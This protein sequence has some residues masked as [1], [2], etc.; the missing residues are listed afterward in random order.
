MKPS[1]FFVTK[2]AQTVVLLLGFLAAPIVLADIPEDPAQATTANQDTDVFEIREIIW[3]GN[4]RTRPRIMQQELLIQ[5]GDRVTAERIEQGRQDVMDLGLFKSVSIDQVPLPN[6]T[7]L[8]VTVDE[9]WYLLPLPRV[10]V[11]S[12]GDVSYGGQFRWNNLTGRNETVKLKLLVRERSDGG[13]EPR[14]AMTY[15]YPLVN[16]SPYGVHFG[17]AH[18]R[19][20]FDD[21]EDLELQSERRAIDF[22]ITRSSFDLGPASKGLKLGVGALWED[23][24][25]SGVGAPVSPGQST[26]LILTGDYN[27]RVIGQYSDTGYSVNTRVEHG[28]KGLNSDFE[29]NRFTFKYQHAFAV[30]EGSDQTFAIGFELGS[31]HGGPG[32]EFTEFSLGGGSTLRGFSRNQFQGDAFYLIRA[33]YLRPIFGQ[34]ALRLLLMADLGGAYRD[35]ESAKIGDAHANVGI[36]IRWRLNW[37]VETE[38]DL[39]IAFPL[40]SGDAKFFGGSV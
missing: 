15:D 36:G 34:R 22:L 23:E 35:W 39:G 38:F 26:A 10:D 8:I 29:Y 20:V 27:A 4:E 32:P 2:T 13:T 1:C 30:N 3:R 14:W 5:A 11:N 19:T 33:E 16:G 25:I 40:E 28:A 6:G 12:D 18:E 37:F 24:E 31:Y 17:L 9:R 7:R 21:I